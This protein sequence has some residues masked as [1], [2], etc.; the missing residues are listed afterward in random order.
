MLEIIALLCLVSALVLLGVLSAID[1]KH[2][3]LPNELVFGFLCLGVIFHLC[4][5]FAYLSVTDM[6]L[7]GF[8]GGGIL[9]LIRAVA[10]QFYGGDALGLGDIKLLAAAGLWLGPYHILI[11]MTLG[12]LAGIAHGLGM[13]WHY[14]RKSKMKVDLA[15]LS[16]PA[17]PGFAVGIIIAA[18]IKFHDLPELLMP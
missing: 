11:A 3:L 4:T 18:V 1:L 17:G 6:I 13:A 15:G 14:R 12:A 5:L 2:G 8:I 9:Y 7:G 16:L 10:I